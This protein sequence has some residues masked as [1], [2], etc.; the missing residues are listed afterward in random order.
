MLDFIFNIRHKVVTNFE[1]IN[2]I[3]DTNDM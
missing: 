2:S 3:I 1:K